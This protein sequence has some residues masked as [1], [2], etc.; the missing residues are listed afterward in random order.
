MEILNACGPKMCCGYRAK[1]EIS[2]TLVDVVRELLIVNQKNDY[3]LPSGL[4]G[5]Y[6]KILYHC[7]GETLNSIN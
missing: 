1:K 2:D 3:R 5:N 4:C 7:A 6:Q